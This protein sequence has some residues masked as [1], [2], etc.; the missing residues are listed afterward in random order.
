MCFSG[1][2]HDMVVILWMFKAG[3]SGEILRGPEGC[4]A[5]RPQFDRSERA[6][7]SSRRRGSAGGQERLQQS[8]G[9]RW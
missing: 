3:I 4:A 9:G 8:A 7:S 1:S 5:P 6:S 2:C